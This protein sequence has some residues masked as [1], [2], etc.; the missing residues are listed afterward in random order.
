M[1]AGT[2]LFG[3]ECQRLPYEFRVG[4]E[5]RPTRAGILEMIQHQCQHA[6][7]DGAVSNP[8]IAVAAFHGGALVVRGEELEHSEDAARIGILR[9]LHGGRV[10]LDAHDFLLQRLFRLE[11]ANGVVVTLRHLP[12]VNAG[13]HGHVAQDVRLRQG[14]DFAE[15]VVELLRDVAADLDVLFLIL[16]DRN[17]V[18]P[19]NEDVCGHQDRIGEEPV[20]R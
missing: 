16:A 14:Q 1:G 13:H 12:A 9:L 20:V 4:F 7:L 15:G 8:A 10:S 11:D 6:L 18:G 3:A 19:V 17:Q 5:L 2:G